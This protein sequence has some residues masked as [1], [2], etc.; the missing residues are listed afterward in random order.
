[1]SSHFLFLSGGFDGVLYI[2]SFKKIDS[3]KDSEGEDEDEEEPKGEEQVVDQKED[4]FWS[5]FSK[6]VNTKEEEKKMNEEEFR[7]EFSQTLNKKD[8]ISCGGLDSKSTSKQDENATTPLSNSKNAFKKEDDIIRTPSPTTAPLRSPPKVE[9][10]I[11][12]LEVSRYENPF[13][14]HH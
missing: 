7:S 12:K 4:S 6:L 14:F 9:S 1:M 10:P 5:D 2:W 13:A 8:D 3:E 11:P